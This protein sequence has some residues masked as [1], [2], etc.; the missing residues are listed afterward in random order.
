M[1]E[2]EKRKAIFLLSQ[3]GMGA[4]EIARRLGISR[5]TVREIIRDKGTNRQQLFRGEVDKYT[6][7]DVGSS[8]VLSDILAAFLYAQLEAREEITQRR[9]ELWNDYDVQLSEWAHRLGIA[10]PT[11][12]PHCEQGFHVYYLILRYSFVL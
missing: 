12:P 1:I 4:R 6:W 5:N 10:T 2:P 8:Y 11:V 3:E 7:V 9:Q